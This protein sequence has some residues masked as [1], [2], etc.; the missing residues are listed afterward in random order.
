M[1]KDLLR[2]VQVED[3]ARGLP[4]LSGVHLRL[5]LQELAPERNR[6]AVVRSHHAFQLKT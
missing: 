4:G 5:H 1:F 2:R 3:A 6:Q